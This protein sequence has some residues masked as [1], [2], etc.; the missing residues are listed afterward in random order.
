[1]PWPPVEKRRPVIENQAMLQVLE[2]RL[3][4]QGPHCLPGL[5]LADLLISERGSP[6]YTATSSGHLQRTINEVLLALDCRTAF[7]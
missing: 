1:V 2:R 7:G 5:A 6:L 3:R 4:G